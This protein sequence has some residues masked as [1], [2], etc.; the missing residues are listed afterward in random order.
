MKKKE[1]KM[2]GAG[3][4]VKLKV[5][6]AN[7]RFDCEEDVSKARRRSRRRGSGIDGEEEI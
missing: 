7:R 1:S 4:E 2:R 3:L 5:S 6:K